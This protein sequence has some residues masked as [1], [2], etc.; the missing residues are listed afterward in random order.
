MPEATHKD[1]LKRLMNVA[2]GSAVRISASRLAREMFHPFKKSNYKPSRNEVS[3]AAERIKMVKKN[4][5]DGFVIE[6]APGETL[7]IFVRRV[8]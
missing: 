1:A 8:H 6:E 3:I 7:S 2:N 5:P 4:P